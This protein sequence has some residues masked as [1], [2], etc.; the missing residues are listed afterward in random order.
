M[1]INVCEEGKCVL[2]LL[3][4]K[5]HTHKAF[6]KDKSMFSPCVSLL[7]RLIALLCGLLMA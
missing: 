1:F 4:V 5:G 3:G 6:C 2:K 7:N